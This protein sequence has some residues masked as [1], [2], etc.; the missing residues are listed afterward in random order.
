MT[1]LPKSWDKRRKIRIVDYK[2][3]HEDKKREVDFIISYKGGV[4]LRYQMTDKWLK[5]G[6]EI[7]NF[8]KW[9]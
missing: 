8:K 6:S 9:L 4:E 3:L 7:N 5:W 1:F 2:I